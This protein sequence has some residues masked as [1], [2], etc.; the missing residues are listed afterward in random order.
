LT[1]QTHDDYALAEHAHDPY[2]PISH[3]H[4]WDTVTDKP[5]WVTT[6]QASVNLTG[7]NNDL[8]LDVD[9]TDVLNK[10]ALCSGS[11]NDLTDKPDIEGIVEVQLLA[12]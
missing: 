10:P 5:T 3:T 1:T 6:S 4:A 7:I 9:W 12:A 11:S 8:S 2:A